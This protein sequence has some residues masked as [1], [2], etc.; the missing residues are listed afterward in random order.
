[1]EVF[2]GQMTNHVL[3]K[4][5]EH[6]ILLTRVPG[7]MTHL[8]QPLDLTVNGYFKQFMKRK[9]VEWYANKI[10]R[11]LDN[12]Q[13]LEGITTEFKLST[14]KPLHAKWVMEEY[15]HMTS[16]IGK[17]ICLKCWKKSRIQ[18]ALENGLEDN[19]DPFKDIDPIETAD[20][21]SKNLFVINKVYIS[22]QNLDDNDSD[23]EYDDGNIFDVFIEDDEGDGE[24]R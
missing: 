5:E 13:D 12:G 3:K 18:D 17:D 14:V 22:Q 19:L 20:E 10:T 1:M 15:N 11:A 21:I 24:T 4:L 9:F 16:Y 2:K 7:N 6:N 8:F 23:W